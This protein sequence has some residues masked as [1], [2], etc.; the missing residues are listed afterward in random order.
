MGGQQEAPCAAGRVADRLAGLGCHG[1]DDGGDQGAG[2]K[3]LTS[4]SLH[5]GG[6]L[7][8]QSLVGIPLDIDTEA[9]PLFLV[10]EVHNQAA[11]LGRVLNLILSLA[12][13][14][15][16]HS[17]T[18]PQLLQGVP[19]V[20]LQ[21]ITIELNQNIPAEALGDRRGLVE[22]CTGLLIRHLE[23][24]QKGQLLQI[25]PIRETIIPEDIAVIPEFLDE[26]GCGH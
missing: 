23:E 16:E 8:Q 12:K 21:I 11:E 5:I 15:P 9:R 4:A 7:F 6:I 26:C 17:R 13:D 18:L 10:D 22:R 14:Q 20:S 2:G 1:I 19:V 3:V 24:E 25:I